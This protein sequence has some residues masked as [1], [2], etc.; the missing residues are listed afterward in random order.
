VNKNLIF[1]LA[2]S[3]VILISLITFINFHVSYL[4]VDFANLE[5]LLSQKRW[6]EADLYTKEIVR[7]ILMQS[8]DDE[9][10]VGFSG[11]DFLG[12]SKTKYLHSNGISC[13]KLKRIDKLWMEGSSGHFGLTVQGKIALSMRKNLHT[14]TGKKNFTWDISELEKKL[15]WSGSSPPYYLKLP[16]WYEPANRP[17]G[18]VGFL[19]SKRWVL[20][21]AGGGKP[22]YTYSDALEHFIKCTEMK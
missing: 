16:E 11:I 9:T 19:P 2:I 6:M 17:E 15:K 12:F 3:S 21:N 10:F 13:E 1:G 5:L 4:K 22:T 14:L 20:D 18:A 8:I 7:K